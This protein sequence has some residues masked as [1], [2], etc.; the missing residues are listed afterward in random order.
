MK[1]DRTDYVMFGLILVSIVVW[2]YALLLMKR[3]FAF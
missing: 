3:L 1:I 2:I